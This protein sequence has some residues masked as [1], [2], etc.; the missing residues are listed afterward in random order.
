MENT[1]QKPETTKEPGSNAGRKPTAPAADSRRKG[2]RKPVKP[3]PD[4]V[5]GTG[6]TM[7]RS[8]VDM[9]VI[10]QSV[11]LAKA[12]VKTALGGSAAGAKLV[13]DL[14]GAKNAPKEPPKEKRRGLT[15]AQQL[16]LD[17]PWVPSP[18]Q[19]REMELD[20]ARHRKLNSF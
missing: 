19:A 15:Y 13:A 14:T 9:L 10:E 20:D 8:A 7:L 3:T 2:G 18:E 4:P 6:G 16:A 12:L 1:E 5:P 17:P 11:A